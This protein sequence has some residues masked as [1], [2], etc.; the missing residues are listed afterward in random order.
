MKGFDPYTYQ[1][2]LRFFYEGEGGVSHGNA[3]KQFSAWL[4][5]ESPN[6]HADIMKKRPDLLKS[7]KAIS[8]GAMGVPGLSGLGEANPAQD[9]PLSEW[10]NSL[11]D[12]A[13]GWMQYDTQRE[14]LKVNL[15]R[16][17]QGLSPISGAS[18]APQVNV[19]VSDDLQKLGIVAV[20]GLIVVGLLAAMRKR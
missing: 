11:L 1:P 2:L 16:A 7:E 6:A 10:G 19:G 9:A 13:K 15:T 3:V 20:G 8:N 5:K 4:Q 12:L 14:L 18:V 17:E